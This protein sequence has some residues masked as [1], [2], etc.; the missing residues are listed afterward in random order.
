MRVAI[1]ASL[2][3]MFG[4]GQVMA[5][6][7]SSGTP[8]TQ[9]QIS[10]LLANRY[11]CVGTSPNAQ[12]NELHSGGLVLDYKKGPT[13]PVDPSDTPSHPTGSYTVT[14]LGSSQTTGTVHYNY[15]AGGTFAY[16]IIANLGAGFPP[17]VSGGQYS[18]CA[19]GGGQNLAVT[20]S[21]THC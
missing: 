15:G 21:A 9:A 2:L 6:N 1:A 8:L 11:A 18:F 20:I 7:C 3:L 10:N 5:Q 13:D 19:V 12:W 4:T 14:G 17:F 16:N